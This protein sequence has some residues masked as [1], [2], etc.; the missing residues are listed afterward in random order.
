[1]SE[2]I[3]IVGP[4]GSGKSTQ[5]EYIANQ[6]EGWYHLSSG[7]LLRRDPVVAKALTSGQLAS[8]EDVDRVVN[9]A[10]EAHRDAKM[11]VFDGFPRTV[12]QLPWLEAAMKRFDLTLKAVIKL[13]ISREEAARRLALRHRADDN[14]PSIAAKWDWYEHKTM[15]LIDHFAKQG[16][17]ISCDGAESVEEIGR[18]IDKVLHV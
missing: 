10:L 12:E 7:D 9:E 11:I 15:P 18:T 17:V 3:I 14:A 6:H 13:D 2:L 8:N 16:L 5:A 4:T 1:M